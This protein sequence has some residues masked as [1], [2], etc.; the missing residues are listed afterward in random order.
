MGRA[1]CCQSVAKLACWQGLWPED[2]YLEGRRGKAE[3]SFR[4]GKGCDVGEKRSKRCRT[5]EMAVLSGWMRRGTQG[6]DA[7]FPGGGFG[8]AGGL[9]WAAEGRVG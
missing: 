7:F 8:R 9:C 5:E 2:F 3:K 6:E 1:G 4:Q